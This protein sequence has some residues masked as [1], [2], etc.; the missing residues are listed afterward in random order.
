MTQYM[1]TLNTL[2]FKLPMDQR[3]LTGDYQKK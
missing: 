3:L 2:L 1:Y